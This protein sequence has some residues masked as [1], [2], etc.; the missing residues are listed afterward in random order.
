MYPPCIC[1]IVCEFTATKKYIKEISIENKYTSQHCC[2]LPR[3]GRLGLFVGARRDGFRRPGRDA[4]HD[5]C[6]ASSIW[7][8]FFLAFNP[9]LGG[10]PSGGVPSPERRISR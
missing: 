6:G 4:C 2:H 3:A 10:T 9:P 5:R 7:R 8:G 1:S